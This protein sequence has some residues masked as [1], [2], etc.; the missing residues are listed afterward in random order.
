[1][2]K[3]KGLSVFGLTM[4]A[5][6]TVIGG[7]FFLGAAI[8]VRNS[9]PAV[10]IAYIIGGILVYSILF[11]LS[12][13]TVADPNPGSF[14]VY[15][16]RAYG[17]GLGFVVGWIY[18]TGLVLAMSSEAVAVSLLFRVWFP[19]LP[20][21]L[22][23]SI[24]IVGVTLINLLGT[25]KLSKLES[26][27]ASIKILAIVGFIVIAFILIFIE[28]KVGLGE[29]RNV[30]L[31]PNGIKGVAGSMLLIMFSFAG[32]EIIGL[33][34]SESPN[35]HRDIPKAITI[36]VISLVTLYVLSIAFL[37]PL[38]PANELNN[39]VSPFVYAL[40]RQNIEWISTA[41]NIILITAILST[42]LAATFGL[43]R[44][45]RSLADEG[46]VPKV[47]KDKG[48]IP[49]IGIIV[50]GVAVY[51]SFSLSFILPE[52][53]YIFLVS[54]GGFSILFTY[55]IIVLS[56]YKLRK[57]NGCPPNGKCQLPLFPISSIFTIIALL[58]IMISMP[59]VVG[60][61]SGLI[62]GVTLIVIFSLIYKVIKI[63]S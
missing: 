54:A 30:P 56:H 51:V 15:A 21:T 2:N 6:G 61:A 11:S 35:P 10:I 3:E 14:R 57:I 37:L 31:L 13:L 36:T 33:A 18:F 38:V 39:D 50:S 28:P 1:M 25:D 4:L 5:L 26:S 23:G 41:F 62:V 40:E 7:S 32:F 12:E 55:L 53:V 60:Q 34:A 48:N 17:E 27:L 20:I 46:C 19:T 59:F 44:M 16:K 29:L 43:G 24:V 22:I 58:L 9:G 49:Y 42:M 47:F 63:K 8:P 45:F 52:E